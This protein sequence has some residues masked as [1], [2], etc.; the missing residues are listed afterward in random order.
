[1]SQVVI[2]GRQVRVSRSEYVRLCAE[3]EK[4]NKAVEEV[5][6]AALAPK[7]KPVAKRKAAKK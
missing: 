4:K 7:K 2:D 3:A 5:A 6:A 1:M